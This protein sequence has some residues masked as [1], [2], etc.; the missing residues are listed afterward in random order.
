MGSVTDSTQALQRP[1]KQRCS[2]LRS[3]MIG[4]YQPLYICGTVILHFHLLAASSYPFSFLEEYCRESWEAS[5][6]E[7]VYYALVLPFKIYLWII[8][9]LVLT[10]IVKHVFFPFGMKVGHFNVELNRWE[11]KVN[12]WAYVRWWSVDHIC[13]ST[14]PFIY[15][16]IIRRSRLATIWYYLLGMK[17]HPFK[18]FVVTAVGEVGEWDLWTLNGKGTVFAMR[19]YGFDFD[20]SNDR[21]LFLRERKETRDDVDVECTGC[22]PIALAWIGLVPSTAALGEAQYINRTHFF[23]AEDFQSFPSYLTL[24]ILFVMFALTFTMQLVSFLRVFCG[25]SNLGNMIV[26]CIEIIPK[27]CSFSILHVWWLRAAGVGVKS[28]QVFS[29][30]D[31][32]KNPSL[33][34]LGRNVFISNTSIVGPCSI[35]DNCFFGI[36]A[37]VRPGARLHDD[38]GVGGHSIACRK[39]SVHQGHVVVRNWKEKRHSSRMGDLAPANAREIKLGERGKITV[40]LF[41]SGWTHFST[42]SPDCC[43]SRYF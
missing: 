9:T 28:T 15:E 13:R 30:C 33:V 23:A 12:S 32:P 40:D 31:T 34:T 39:M 5:H 35:G 29:G 26:E 22:V 6:F 1:A 20:S 25:E 14:T 37:R 21:I 36:K 38:T 41:P 19:S 42:F 18:S 27:T 2:L 8:V 43:S 17:I 10:A 4:L 24:L 3:I 16:A 7:L 11:I